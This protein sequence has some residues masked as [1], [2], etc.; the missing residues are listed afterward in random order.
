MNNTL[1]KDALKHTSNVALTMSG[2]KFDYTD[3]E[4]SDAI[5]I[6]TEVFLSKMYDHHREKLSIEQMMELAEEGGK[7]MHETVLLFTGVDLHKVYT[8]EVV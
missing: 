4:L 7:K 5:L 2:K 1:F 6:F 3:E 8:K